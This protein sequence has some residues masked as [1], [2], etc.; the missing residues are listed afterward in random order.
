MIVWISP[1]TR[2]SRRATTIA[3]IAASR[4]SPFAKRWPNWESLNSW[5]PP[6]DF[7]LK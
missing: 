5:M 4:V 7:T 2:T 1:R 6:P 3:R